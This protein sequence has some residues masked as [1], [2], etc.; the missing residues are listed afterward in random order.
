MAD[1][2]AELEKK[3]K[4][5]EELRKATQQTKKDRSFKE[6]KRLHAVDRYADVILSLV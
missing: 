6:V 4:K 5:L 1:R 3:R 2:K